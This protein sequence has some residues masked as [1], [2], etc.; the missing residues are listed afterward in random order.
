MATLILGLVT[1]LGMHS[2]RIFADDWRTAQRAR[3]GEK[4]WKLG[5]TLISLV[6]FGLIIWG[7]GM[8][9]ND[10]LVLWSPPVAMRHIASLLTLISFVLLAATYV[11]RNG[12]KA[13]L[14][15]PMVLGVTVWAFAHLLANGTL[16]DVILFGSFLVWAKLSYLAAR[17][18]DRMA[19]TRYPAGT[20]GG[21]IAAVAAGGVAW[22]LFAF[23]LHGLLIGVNP[24]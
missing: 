17:K 24:L 4:A 10:P 14:H 5:Y 19:G 23:W 11:P 22:M 18:R 15:H 7:F 13:R 8:A 21:T 12:I 6:G 9:R 1:F 3:Y 2:V 16:A 20:M